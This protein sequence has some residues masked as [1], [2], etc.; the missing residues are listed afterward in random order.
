M[1]TIIILKERKGR[2]PRVTETDLAHISGKITFTTFYLSKAGHRTSPD[3]KGGD[4][5]RT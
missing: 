1:S 4:H 2:V 3:S 5:K